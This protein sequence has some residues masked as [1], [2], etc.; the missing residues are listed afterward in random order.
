MPVPRS[1]YLVVGAIAAPVGVLAS[2][3]APLAGM[4]AGAIAVGLMLLVTAAGV[5]LAA[6]WRAEVESRQAW[7]EVASAWAECNT[8][9][10]LESAD[11]DTRYLPAIAND[12]LRRASGIHH[13]VLPSGAVA[14]VELPAASSVPRPA[15]ARALATRTAWKGLQG[16]ASDRGNDAGV[17]VGGDPAGHATLER[18]RP[19]KNL[20]VAAGEG[21]ASS[22]RVAR[23]GAGLRLA[24]N[25]G[26]GW[27]ASGRP[28]AIHEAEVIVLAG[29]R[30]AQRM[31]PAEAATETV[32]GPGIELPS[33]RGPPPLGRERPAR[34]AAGRAAPPRRASPDGNPL[35]RDNFGQ[36]VPICAAE[37]NVIETYLGDAL[38]ELFASSKAASE[39]EQA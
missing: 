27:P 10:G 35:V 5:L 34:G 20:G 3:I 29:C 36:P 21:T 39:P 28:L 11:I 32:R 6:D 33:C 16:S 31:R 30:D 18:S 22:C 9:V 15:P 2:A 38:D 25:A 37:V 7:A 4:L 14:A 23:G 12:A 26:P 17:S 19:A 13:D 1:L 24:V 8:S